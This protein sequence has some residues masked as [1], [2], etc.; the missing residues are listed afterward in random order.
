M[1]KCLLS[2]PSATAVGVRHKLLWQ[3][4]NDVRAATQDNPLQTALTPLRH[5]RMVP[6]YCSKETPTAT[7]S[8]NLIIPSSTI[9]SKS[10]CGRK[11]QE[12]GRRQGRIS[13]VATARLSG[14]KLPVCDSDWSGTIRLDRWQTNHPPKSSRLPWST[15]VGRGRAC[16]AVDRS[17]RP[18]N[19]T[20]DDCS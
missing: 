12:A 15:T 3:N 19:C 6:R 5:H 20:H 10:E 4:V 1:L 13:H 11:G 18:C 17:D 16:S 7:L 2:N 14:R 9:T 8:V